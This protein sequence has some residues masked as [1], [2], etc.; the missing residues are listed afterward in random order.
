ME[1]PGCDCCL[2]K[3]ENT[4]GATIQPVHR[5]QGPLPANN[6]QAHVYSHALGT[7]MAAGT[8]ITT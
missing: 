3:K 5:Q 8:G 7:A 4:L 6:L 1:L 2:G